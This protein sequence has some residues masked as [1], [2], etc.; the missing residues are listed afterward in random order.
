MLDLN[1]TQMPDAPVSSWNPFAVW[2]Y[3]TIEEQRRDELTQAHR[4]LLKIQRK[5]EKYE[6]KEN[7]LQ[8]RIARLG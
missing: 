2:F 1:P 5:L 6:A 8:R 7:M 3:K 4:K